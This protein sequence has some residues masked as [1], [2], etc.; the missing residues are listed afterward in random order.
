MVHK[1]C[2]AAPA[3]AGEGLNPQARQW[4]DV[5]AA[6]DDEVIVQVELLRKCAGKK[7]KKIW[8]YS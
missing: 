6:E 4:V 5:S 8:Q 2:D 1:S 7:V 3:V